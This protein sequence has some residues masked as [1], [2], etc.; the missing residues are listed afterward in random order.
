VAL[1]FVGGC[2][3]QLASSSD[4]G[5]NGDDA[6]L[7]P[8][9]GAPGPV[10]DAAV[11]AAVSVAVDAAVS[12]AVDAAVDAAVSVAVD[13]ATS[14]D[15]GPAV[16]S[17]GCGMSSSLATGAW[18]EQT[19]DVAGTARTYFVWLPDGYD[20]TRAY[21]VIYQFHG[22]ADYREWNNPPIERESGADAILVRGRAV[23]P[24][25][26]TSATGPDVAFF[27]ALV[28]H[29]EASFC[30]D[31]ARRFV[32]GYSSGAFM[33]HRLACVRGDL[34]RGVATIAGGHTRRMCAGQVAALLIHDRDD[35][36]VNISSSR[37]TRDALL[38]VN[39]CNADAPRTP[40][41]YAP[42]ERYAGCDD[43]FPVV[44]CET[45]GRGHSRQDELAAPAFWDFFSSLP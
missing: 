19:L 6:A 33:S 12:V 34:I 35:G 44:W 28:A 43:G 45:S 2:Q 38:S 37:D 42:C 18:V 15:A 7:V 13:A 22:C 24:C 4:A 8:T 26:D 20:P 40:T 30:A 31:P 23:G 5:R 21:P 41:A 17:V 25:W 14:R 39:G 29:M 32:T 3:G 27:D 16:G 9:D 10:Q 36:V 11:D 1:S